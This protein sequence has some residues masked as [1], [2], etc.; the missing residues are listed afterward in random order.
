MGWGPVDLTLG[1]VYIAPVIVAGLLGL[2]M[3]LVLTLLANQF[4]LGRFVWHP[5]LFFAALL[6]V[7]TLVVGTRVV[8][9]FFG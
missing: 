8:P 9:A 2:V 6:V 4:G 5:P 1:G 7:C 3:T